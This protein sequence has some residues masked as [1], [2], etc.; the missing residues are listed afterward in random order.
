M[1]EPYHIRLNGPW[2]MTSDSQAEP[3]RV[4]L[5]KAWPQILQAAS[6]E[7]VTLMRWFHRPTGIDDGSQVELHLSDLPFAGGAWINDVSL[8]QF[9]AKPQHAIDVH[10]HV[11]ERSCLT[12]AI[13]ELAPLETSIPTPQISLAILPAR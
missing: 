11:T 5:P 8:G 4:K 2:E 3:I 9:S 12:I 7:T 13:E 1:T 10:Q 6:A